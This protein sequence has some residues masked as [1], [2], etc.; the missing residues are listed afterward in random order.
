MSEL[1]DKPIGLLRK[2]LE[3]LQSYLPKDYGVM[4]WLYNR[5]DKDLDVTAFASNEGS[6]TETLRIL[7]AT[8]AQLIRRD[9]KQGAVGVERYFS[10][11]TG[12]SPSEHV[13]SS[14][15]VVLHGA[16]DRVRIWSRGG[17]AGELVVEAGDGAKIATLLLM[18]EERV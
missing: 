1:D 9:A 11:P 16:H 13:V 4:C 6:T 2:L 15:A 14:A 10:A 3:Q 18:L 12:T 8:A 7:R 17:L 5:L